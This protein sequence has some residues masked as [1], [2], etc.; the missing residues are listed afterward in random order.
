MKKFSKSL[1]ATLPGLDNLASAWLCAEIDA[2]FAKHRSRHDIS[3]SEKTH[4]SESIIMVL[5]ADLSFLITTIQ[6]VMQEQNCQ[7]RV[8]SYQ[9]FSVRRS[10]EGEI[11]EIIPYT[12]KVTKKGYVTEVL[13]VL[14]FQKERAKLQCANI[15]KKRLKLLEKT[16][17]NWNEITKII[18]AVVPPHKHGKKYLEWL[19]DSHF[20]FLG[21][22]YTDSKLSKWKNAAGILTDSAYTPS[23]LLGGVTQKRR[24]RVLEDT[25]EITF[26]KSSM[27]SPL[28]RYVPM[29]LI[30][31]PL[32]KTAQQPHD[33]FVIVGLYTS[34]AY[35][36]GT[37][38]IPYISENISKVISKLGLGEGWHD[39][40]WLHH[41]YDSLPRDEIFQSDSAQLTHIGR[42]VLEAKNNGNFG[43]IITHDAFGRYTNL[44]ALMPQQNFDTR[45]FDRLRIHLE[46]CLG[47][48]TELINAAVDRYS[49]AYA[50][51]RV[52]SDRV[53]H[54]KIHDEI[55]DYLKLWQDKILLLLQNNLEL[56]TAYLQIMPNGYPLTYEENNSPKAGVSDLVYILDV[57]ANKKTR[58]KIWRRSDGNWGLKIYIPNEDL[59]LTEIVSNLTN[60]G[61]QVANEIVYEIDTSSGEKVW[62]HDLD[63]TCAYDACAFGEDV[64]GHLTEALER[65]WS[66]RLDDS[67]ANIALL[68]F[69]VTWRECLLMKCFLQYMRQL[70]FGYASKSLARIFT[71]YGSIISKI[72]VLF[73]CRHDTRIKS[74]AARRLAESEALVAQIFEEL[75]AFSDH[76]AERWLR[77][78]TQV[79]MA[80]VRTNFYKDYY[81]TNEGHHIALKVM[82]SQLTF[83]VSPKPYCEIFVYGDGFEGVHL[84]GGKV[85]RGGIRWSDRG[86]DYR[87]EVYG[88]LMAQVVKN[89]VIVPV[90]SK[91]GFYVRKD[92]KAFDDFDSYRAHAVECYRSFVRA[93]IRLTDNIVKAKTVPPEGVVCLDEEDP[94]LVV[95]A[96]KGTATFSDYAN[97]VSREE[98]FW[99]D[100][101]FASGG[102]HG[103]DHKK[104]GITAKGAWVSVAHH[105]KKLNINVNEEIFSVIGIGDMSGD[106]FGNGMLLSEKISLI[107][108]FDH[109][110]IFIDPKPNVAKSYKERKR[111]FGLSRSSWEDYDR[112]L[113]S[114]GGGVFSRSAKRIKLTP[115]IVEALAIAE[116]PSEMSA[117]ELVKCIL[118]AQAD[119][120]WFGGIGTFVSASFETPDA[121]KDSANN[122][123]RVFAKELRAKVV[124]EGANLGITQQGRIEFARNGGIINT[125]SIDNSAGVNCSDYEV[126]IKILLGQ[127]I[128]TK[129]LTFNQRNTM[130][131]RMTDQV[132][133]LVLKNNYE[134]NAL[135]SRTERELKLHPP[136]LQLLIDHLESKKLIQ[137]GRELANDYSLSTITRPELSLIVAHAKN[138]WINHLLT[139]GFD[140]TPFD[141]FL[142]SYFPDA[143][144]KKYAR[145]IKAHPLANNIVLTG[146]INTMINNMGLGFLVLLLK[147][148]GASLLDCLQAWY[149]MHHEFGRDELVEDL[150]YATVVQIACLYLLQK[151][152][153]QELDLG[154]KTMKLCSANLRRNQHIDNIN[155]LMIFYGLTV[156]H[157]LTKKTKLPGNGRL[158]E[159]LGS[160]GLQTVVR[161]LI[162]E[163][164]MSM[165]ENSLL[166]NA[167]L[168]LFDKVGQ[169]FESKRSIHL[170]EPMDVLDGITAKT[171]VEFPTAERLVLARSYIEH[172]QR[173][174]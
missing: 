9:R 62:I 157:S 61:L 3:L 143:L 138:L 16:N 106:V 13:V 164:S 48:Q 44:L 135:L 160:E 8:F 23:E 59:S 116:A 31:I 158:S 28:H 119:L 132:V 150:N 136:R 111:L 149:L 14:A 7:A 51:Y 53:P 104:L 130:L 37:R 102:A 87:T 20:S 124:G 165:A 161:A 155:S 110:N 123:V 173:N 170:L 107:A 167:M 151:R 36:V 66:G 91:G 148:S 55:L 127:E 80:V 92:S 156:H 64:I 72:L 78:L 139:K 137:S 108:A 93:L 15:L 131:E 32:A 35:T 22:A 154:S 115:E 84:R 98:N 45:L 101:A 19:V 79:V 144:R 5:A 41:M 103:Y 85:A 67:I 71:T 88:L 141:G 95:A 94:Y 38:Y 21:C 24:Q 75:D 27:K 126:N 118:R 58:V 90:G 25:D 77:G 70:G 30:F 163:P 74:S 146:L 63:A 147:E 60:F 140:Q 6:L 49:L 54:K 83:L 99:L 39:G 112:R 29:D 113:I 46:T 169:F 86:E 10:P 122:A 100:D 121:V 1:L 50:H 69:N 18:D 133:E 17:A 42:G 129:K 168:E 73:K 162:P 159:T 56:K 12:P 43:L 57:V 153:Q 33:Y 125:D 52:Q 120:L 2:L 96:D 128:A 109:R 105:L 142:H 68:G 40:K 81:D 152:S 145:K 114:A 4:D 65:R 117:D 166:S 11:Q 134:Q 171:V 47:K 34:P 174:K 172:L 76:E 82:S 26:C 97:E 89:S